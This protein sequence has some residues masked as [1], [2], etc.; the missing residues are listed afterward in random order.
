MKTNTKYS[1]LKLVKNFFWDDSYKAESDLNISRKTLMTNYIIIVASFFLISFGILAFLQENYII[2]FLD[3]TVFSIIT[4]FRFFYFK[5]HKTNFLNYIIINIFGVYLLFL[6]YRGGLHLSGSLWSFIFPVTVMFQVGR[7][8]GRIYILAF[9]TIVILLFTFDLTLFHYS[10]N[11]KLRFVGSFL[12]VSII[13]YFIEFIR[14][15]TQFALETTNKE[16]KISFSNLEQK[17]KALTEREKHYRTL[18]EA[19]NDAIFLMDGNTFIDCNP[20]TLEMFG[21]KREEIIN[22]PPYNFSPKFQPDGELSKTKAISKI[23][24]ALGGNSQVFEWTHCKLNKTEFYAEVRLDAVELNNKKL[25]LASVRDITDRKIASDKLKIAKENAEKSD[26][27]KSDFLAQ[28][29][30]EIRTPINTILNYTSL[31]QMEF[32]DNVSEEN[33]GSFKAIQKSA[34]RLIR[35]IDLILNISDVEAGTYE[36][37]FENIDILAKILDPIV[38]EFHPASA[39]KKLYLTLKYPQDEKCCISYIDSYTIYQAISNLV[40]NAIKYTDSGG[41]EIVVEELEKNFLIKISDT[42]I[43]ISDEYLPHLFE[44]FSQEESGYSRKYEGNGLGLSL[45]KKYCEINNIIISVESKKGLGTTF[46]L[47]FNKVC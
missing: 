37:V 42:G 20:R 24:A 47:D 36:P 4:A 18:F 46:I 17:E 21:C 7:K 30:H 1:F 39:N 22:Q 14:E 2:G 27:L 31:L 29:S 16:I 15:K 26:R 40:D 11:F 28:M 19:S 10:T 13:S 43:G 35:T 6:I 8:I 32:E 41:I 25:L 3:M 34:Q 33:A 23:E 9:L 38:G 45:V 12:A 44:K 5:D